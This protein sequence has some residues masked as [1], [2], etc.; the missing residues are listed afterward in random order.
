MRKLLFGLGL[1]V[2][3]AL[4]ALIGRDKV[5]VR[6]AP[7]EPRR[8]SAH[9]ESHTSA[10]VLARAWA[11][12]M[13]YD[14]MGVFCR[15]PAVFA[16]TVTGGA[17]FAGVMRLQLRAPQPVAAAES[18]SWVARDVADLAALNDA[19]IAAELAS[20]SPGMAQIVRSLRAGNFR[21]KPER[22]EWIRIAA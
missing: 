16:E 22:T 2:A 4:I 20:V 18:A 7:A 13:W 19:D 17:R 12:S 6:P 3:A 11:G 14:P 8:A 21:R 15:T 5:R 9:L 1:A 10:P